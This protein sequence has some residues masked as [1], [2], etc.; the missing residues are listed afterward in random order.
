MDTTFLQK[1]ETFLEKMESLFDIFRED[2]AQRRRLKKCEK[3]Y[4]FA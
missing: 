2:N 3:D 1:E 4:G